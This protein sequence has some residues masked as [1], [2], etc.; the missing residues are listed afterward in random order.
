MLILIYNICKLMKSKHCLMQHRNRG[1]NM[2]KVV[3]ESCTQEVRTNM[4]HLIHL[5][6]HLVAGIQNLSAICYLQYFCW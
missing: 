1:T 6:Y 4:L 2:L 3:L 5:Q